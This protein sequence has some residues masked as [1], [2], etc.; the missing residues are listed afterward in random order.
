MQTDRIV[1]RELG[2]PVGEFIAGATSK[3][4]CL[5]EFKDRGGIEK[6]AKRL[7]KRYKLEMIPGTNSFTDQLASEL[8]QYFEGSRKTFSVALDLR[9]TPFQLAVWR[10]LLSI[11]YGGTRSY[12][13][14]A[15]LVGR[16][17]AVRAVGRANGD[18][19][20]AIVVPCHRVIQHDGKLRGYGGGLWRKRY[21]LDLE[22]GGRLPF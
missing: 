12:G 20:L 5:L 21:L 16:P 10:Q 7:Y 9:G 17:S 13:E 22:N 8:A 15:E 19:A 11:P 2:S 18:N 6:I 14:V 4:C 1:Y 3:G